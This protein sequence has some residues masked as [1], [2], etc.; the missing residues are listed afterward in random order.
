MLFPK[1]RNIDARCGHHPD[2]DSKRQ[3]RR[4]ARARSK[5]DRAGPQ[6]RQPNRIVFMFILRTSSA[7]CLRVQVQNPILKRFLVANKKPLQDG[8][9][10]ASL[11]G[12]LFLGV[13]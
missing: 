1:S 12:C 8:V 9:C 5:H 13:S 4:Q 2:T 11:G 3:P 10:L 6:N 7:Q